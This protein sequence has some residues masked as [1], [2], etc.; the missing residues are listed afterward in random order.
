MSSFMGTAHASCAAPEISVSRNDPEPGRIIRVTG[1]GFFAE[2]NDVIANGVVPPPSPPTTG[3][4]VMFGQGD[5]RAILARVDATADY[6]FVVDV[7]I[8]ESARG[9]TA[10]ISADNALPVPIDVAES[11]NDASKFVV[12]VGAGLI[13]LAIGITGERWRRRRRSPAQGA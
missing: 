3:I 6:S 10:Q 4:R 2:C 13:V 12:L 1:T 9:G 8:P 11:S 7:R 5:E